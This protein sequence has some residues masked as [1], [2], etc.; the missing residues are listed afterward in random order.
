MSEVADRLKIVLAGSAGLGTGAVAMCGWGI[1]AALDARFGISMGGALWGALGAGLGLIALGTVALRPAFEPGMWRL[2]PSVALSMLGT[3]FL[4]GPGGSSGFPLVPPGSPWSMEAAWSLFLH[5][6][7]ALTPFGWSLF[8]LS[9]V[10]FPITVG[11]LGWTVRLFENWKRELGGASGPAKFRSKDGVLGDADWEKWERLRNLVQPDPQHGIFFA[12]DYNPCNNPEIFNPEDPTTWGEG[13]KAEVFGMSGKFLSG[14]LLIFAGSGRGKTSAVL[15][16]TCLRSLD[17]IIAGD[18]NGAAL[19]LVRR[20]REHMGKKVREIRVGH[21]FDVLK[22]LSPWLKKSSA[23][24][25]TVAGMIVD[26]YR[27][28]ESDV[29]DYFKKEGISVIAALLEHFMKVGGCN[30]FLEVIKVITKPQGAFK[31]IITEVAGKYPDDSTIH[32]KLGAYQEVESRFYQSFSNVVRQALEWA[33]YPEYRAI[34]TEEPEGEPDILAPDTDVFITI[35]TK[36]M[37]NYP[38]L[39]R[40]IYGSI[41]YCASEGAEIERLII[42]DEAKVLGRMKVFETIFQ[43]QRKEGLRLTLIFQSQAQLREDFGPNGSAALIDS[44][45]ARC[46]SGVED[47]RTARD[48]SA[49]IGDYTVEVSGSNRSTS[50]RGFGL[51]SQSSSKGESVTQHKVALLPINDLRALPMDCWLIFYGGQRPLRVGK[52]YWFRRQEWV[53]LVN[54]FN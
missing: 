40:L 31:E 27:M 49:L 45:A 53:D 39:A 34:V 48:L 30:P 29:G 7:T 38:G 43:E 20:V 54:S 33:E 1:G 18:P 42:V 32:L 23:A 37:K 14:H 12:E 26:E 52:A 8:G 2:I 25:V 9:A 50:A 13:G 17:T 15:I 10:S 11:G 24:Y 21:G 28:N 22:L 5:G 44:A 47:E 16:P 3:T 6:Q 36:D 46:Y 41:S 51:S 4:I 19:N 35:P